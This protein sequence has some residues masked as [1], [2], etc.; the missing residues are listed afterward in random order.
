MFKLIAVP[1]DGSLLAEK[2]LAY[3]TAL[4][5]SF[6]ADILLLRGAEMPLLMNDKPPENFSSFKQAKTYLEGLVEK[7]A[8]PTDTSPVVKAQVIIGDE[9]K[10]IVATITE[11]HADLIVMTTHGRTGL[12]RLL[13]GSMATTILKHA[14]CP[15]VIIRPNETEENLPTLSRLEQ[16]V[17][18]LD[19]T[20]EAEIILEPVVEIAR[21][22]GA[23]LNIVRVVMPFVPV[24]IGDMEAGYSGFD[25]EKV[26]ETWIAEAEDYIAEIRSRLNKQGINCEAK[27]LVGMP[28]DKILD[29]IEEIKPQMVAMATHARGNLEQIVIGSVADEVLRKC[30]LPVLMM[31]MPKRTKHAITVVAEEPLAITK[32]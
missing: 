32:S 8:L 27:V 11:E 4:A 28:S 7:L 16:I 17:V 14:P 5:K 23:K 31:H 22:V 15:L 6:N 19:G 24:N 2:A 29:F 18:T 26:T 21:Q 25:I 1:L 12:M 3:S 13:M 20:V 9:A 10:D 30:N